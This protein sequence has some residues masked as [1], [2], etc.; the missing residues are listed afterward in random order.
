MTRSNPE[1]VLVSQTIV[2]SN[3]TPHVPNKII[4]NSIGPAVHMYYFQGHYSSTDHFKGD[5]DISYSRK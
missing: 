4:E 5:D 2:L 1:H 3:F